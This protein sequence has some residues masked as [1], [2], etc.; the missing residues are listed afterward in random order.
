MNKRDKVKH[1]KFLNDAKAIFK[2]KPFFNVFKS[3]NDE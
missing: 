2:P 3:M 1:K